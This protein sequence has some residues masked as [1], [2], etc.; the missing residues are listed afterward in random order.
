MSSA[1]GRTSL[2][3]RTLRRATPGAFRRPAAMGQAGPA[4]VIAM[5]SP[6]TPCGDIP[7]P[8][9]LDPWAP[10]DH[11]VARSGD[12]GGTDDVPVAAESAERTA[13][14]PPPGLGDPPPAERAGR[15]GPPLVH[16]DHPDTRQL[17]L[18]LQSPDEMRAPPGAQP[19]VLDLAS[20]PVADPL[21]VSHPQGP[22]PVVDRPGHDCLG[23]LMLSLADPP[24]MAGLLASL[25]PPKLAPAPRSPLASA[26]GLAPH[27]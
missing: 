17:G 27:L 10:T 5:A 23:S 25:A 24:S 19:E 21:G 13:E 6:V 7:H 2:P 22:H 4:L 15:G 8:T 14:G 20:V 9:V 12:V 26:R 1:D 11:P 18:V 16:L 3:L